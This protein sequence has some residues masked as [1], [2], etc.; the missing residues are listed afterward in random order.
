MFQATNAAPR[1]LDR[2][3]VVPV[4]GVAPPLPAANTEQVPRMTQEE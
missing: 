1:L 2:R 3:L 4:A